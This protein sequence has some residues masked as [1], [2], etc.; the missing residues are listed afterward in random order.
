M[1]KFV[2]VSACMLLLSLGAFAQKGEAYFGASALTAG[3]YGWNGDAGINVSKPIVLEGDLGG[4]Y[5]NSENIYS[6]M[7][8]VKLQGHYHKRGFNPWGRFLFGVSHDSQKDG[9]TDNARSWALGGGVD[10]NIYHN[11]G[12]R[13]SADAFHTHFFNSGTWRVRVGA[14]LVYHF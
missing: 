6:Y 9:A 12:V 8:G 1:R 3:K 2:L 10:A 13:L 14:G 11:F 4:Y 5:S 7:G